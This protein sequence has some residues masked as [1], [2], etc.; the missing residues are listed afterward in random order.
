MANL[1]IAFVRRVRNCERIDVYPEVIPVDRLRRLRP[2]WV[3]FV[4]VGMTGLQ[5]VCFFGLFW[6]D[7]GLFWGDLDY[8]DRRVPKEGLDAAI[9]QAP[10]PKI[11][12]S[13]PLATLLPAPPKFNKQPI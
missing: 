7:L 10:L 1:P 2:S 4:A 11:D 5:L 6:G 3:Y 8:G 12:T 9:F 13:S